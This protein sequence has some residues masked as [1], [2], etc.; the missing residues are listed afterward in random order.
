MIYRIEKVS[1]N[2]EKKIITDVVSKSSVHDIIKS[3]YTQA[4]QENK[5]MTNKYKKIKAISIII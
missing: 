1:S 5:A 3:S 2:E 4:Y